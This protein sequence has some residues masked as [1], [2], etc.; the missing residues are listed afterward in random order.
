MRL[1]KSVL[2]HFV[3]GSDNIGRNPTNTLDMSPYEVATSCPFTSVGV[4]A[5]LRATIQHLKKLLQR[6]RLTTK[7][8][9]VTKLKE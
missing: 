6:I 2:V 7:L 1:F 9:I 3:L 8:R 4:P 5:P